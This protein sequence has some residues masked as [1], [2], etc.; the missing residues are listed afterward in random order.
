MNNGYSQ[1]NSATLTGLLDISAT[2]I[3]STVIDASQIVINGVDITTQLNQVPINQSNIAS[4]QQITTGVS[5]S[6]VGAIDLTTIDNNVTV[7]KNL[8]C[9]YAPTANDDVVNKLYSDSVISSTIQVSDSDL[10]TIYYPVFATAGAGSKSL[11]FDNIN[12]PLKYTPSLGWLETGAFKS[13]NTY[14][15]N[16]GI[17]SQIVNL[18]NGGPIQMYCNTAGGVQVNAVSLTATQM[19][20]A[21][22]V[23]ATQ[24][25]IKDSAGIAGAGVIY[26]TNPSLVFV[27]QQVS[28]SM[29]F[30]VNDAVGGTKTATY[31]TNSLSL[32]VPIINTIPTVGNNPSFYT[33]EAGGNYIYMVPR[34]NAGGYNS[35]SVAGD[36]IIFAQGP[37]IGTGVLNLTS[38]SG[39]STGVRITPTD[40]QI[41]GNASFA[42]IPSCSVAPTT[43][44]HLTNK[45]Y[46]DAVASGSG[47]YITTNTVQTITADKT[48]SNADIFLSDGGT[49]TSTINQI[50][51]NTNITLNTVDNTTG[52]ITGIIPNLNINCIV[53]QD[54]ASA[55]Q[56]GGAITGTNIVVPYTNFFLL[57]STIT[58]SNITVISMTTISSAQILSVGSTMS[59]FIGVRFALGTYVT[60]IVGGGQYT[61]FPLAL[62]MSFPSASTTTIYNALNR[63][64]LVGGNFSGTIN[65]DFNKSLNL[66]I[67][68]TSSVIQNAVEITQEKINMNIPLHLNDTFSYFQ[69]PTITG[70]VVLD[71]L[72]APLAQFYLITSILPAVITLPSPIAKY[73]GTVIIFKRRSQTQV[74]TISPTGGGSRMMP[75]NTVVLAPTVF[76]TASQFGCQMITDG[77]NWY[78]MML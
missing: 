57:S 8:K 59:S 73:S 55:I 78:Q 27:N 31:S 47:T 18:S 23:S 46:V 45:T 61:I 62:G 33:G 30:Q 77:V 51:G 2:S 35:T 64:Y 17:N 41:S 65:F 63:P 75:Y 42:S 36:C 1:I 37:T 3:T 67:K 49:N 7:S 34:A 71:W 13:G 70:S 68:D 74:I 9:S 16:V 38:W 48:F 58:V 40:V 44:N 15:Q 11:F 43:A 21:V 66:Q 4:L 50:V 69:G 12:S 53:R 32:Q 29:L 54:A 19:N 14:Y 39:T 20:V 25:I 22:P 72:A 24:C 28:G 6:N 60:G 26:L 56:A 76:M 10:G 52:T 5:Y